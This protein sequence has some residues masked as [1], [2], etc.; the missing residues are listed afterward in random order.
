MTAA[1]DSKAAEL[2]LQV[3]NPLASWGCDLLTTWEG[4][5]WRVGY[6]K[7]PTR[8]SSRT[9]MRCH[10]RPS[11]EAARVRNDRDPVALLKAAK[12]TRSSMAMR[13]TCTMHNNL[14]LTI[15]S[16]ITIII[17]T[18][19]YLGLVILSRRISGDQSF[20]VPLTLL[21]AE[22]CSAPAWPAS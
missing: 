2:K 19:S 18:L 13:S 21:G 22:P 17:N 5:S 3:L 11:Q 8:S 4:R 16:S 10:R 15:L 1:A 14:N 20:T 7:D 12:N 9:A 6:E